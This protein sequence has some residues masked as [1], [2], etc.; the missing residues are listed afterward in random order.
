LRRL[1]LLALLGL[2]A[3]GCS[4]TADEETT[5]TTA[6]PPWALDPGAPAGSGVTDGAGW[7]GIVAGETWRGWQWDINAGGSIDLAY[8]GGPGCAGWASRAPTVE[9][10]LPADGGPWAFSYG[11]VPLQGGWD[12][13]MV[14]PGA[15][16]V[17]QSPD[18]AFAC[19]ADYQRWQGWQG[20]FDSQGPMVEIPLLKAGTYDV[21]VGAPE[22]TSI[23]GRL[24]IAAP[25]AVFPA[26]TT[27]TPTTSPD[28]PPSEPATTAGG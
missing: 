19:R 2:L 21:W 11:V 23:F 13:V 1:L 25:A 22:G 15:V 7:E 17:V 16:L 18:G 8:P 9:V 3:A 27:T 28:E 26:T 4:L 10:T 14:P 24:V 12:T 6:A 20:W 5:T